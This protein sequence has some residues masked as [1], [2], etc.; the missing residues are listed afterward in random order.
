[1]HLTSI[2]TY[3]GEIDDKHIVGGVERFT[4]EIELV[5][6][7]VSIYAA[8]SCSATVLLFNFN[9]SYVLYPPLSHL[10]NAKMVKKLPRP[11]TTMSNMPI[12]M[13]KRRKLLTAWSLVVVVE[14]S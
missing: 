13:P 5:S 6:T 12:M 11:P 8:T 7:C 9:T 3:Y 4:S 10:V 2:N 1:M 14:S